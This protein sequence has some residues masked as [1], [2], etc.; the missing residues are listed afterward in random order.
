M[1]LW[2]SWRLNRCS[3]EFRD[4]VLYPAIKELS[5]FKDYYL[6]TWHDELVTSNHDEATAD[7]LKKFVARDELLAD[8]KLGKKQLVKD[9]VPD[10]S[11]CLRRKADGSWMLLAVNNR[12]EALDVTLN[13][14]L[15]MP[16]KVKEALSGKDVKVSGKVIKDK[17]APFDVKVYLWSEK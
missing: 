6:G 14:D 12:R 13:V 2:A 5:Q 11:Y 16:A 9:F 10:I 17:F 1:E 7:Y 15:K 3:Q 4:N 8:V